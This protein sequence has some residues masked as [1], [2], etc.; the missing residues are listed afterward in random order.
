MM[1]DHSYSGDIVEWPLPERLIKALL[2]A[3]GLISE[4]KEQFVLSR[5]DDTEEAA[6]KRFE[7]FL[8]GAYAKT[9]FSGDRLMMDVIE[10]FAK[11]F[12]DL[13]T[14]NFVQQIVDLEGRINPLRERIPTSHASQIAIDW[15]VL[16]RLVVPWAGKNAAIV[17]Q[18]L[19]SIDEGMP[20]GHFW[21]LPQRHANGRV[22]S[23]LATFFAWWVD[24]CGMA[25]RSA[26]SELLREKL[27]AKYPEDDWNNLS[28]EIAKWV[29]RKP[30]LPSVEKIEKIAHVAMEVPFSDDV[31]QLQNEGPLQGRVC[32]C[33][34]FAVA[35][36]YDAHSLSLEIP[37]RVEQI[38]EILTSV[39]EDRS[40]NLEQ[41]TQ[42]KFV[43][44]MIRR[45]QKPT[46]AQIRVRLLLARTIQD[47]FSRISN[48]FGEEKAHAL[49]VIFRIAYN[50]TI[51]LRE[52]SDYQEVQKLRERFSE[53]FGR[54]FPI[55][56]DAPGSDEFL[57]LALSY[58]WRFPNS[59]END[60][61]PI[62]TEDPKELFK[63]VVR[64]NIH[65]MLNL[66]AEAM[67][68]E[69]KQLSDLSL[70]FDEPNDIA[71][72][73]KEAQKHL[74]SA[75]EIIEI[76]NEDDLITQWLRYI[77]SPHKQKSHS[78]LHGRVA[79]RIYDGIFPLDDDPIWS[80][81]FK[82]ALERAT[83]SEAGVI[84]E[85]AGLTLEGYY[86]TDIR[87]NKRLG[88][89]KRTEVCLARLKELVTQCG[90]W[91]HY[92]RMFREARFLV[93]TGDL[94]KALPL[95][96]T[97]L[98]KGASNIAPATSDILEDALTVASK[99][100]KF[101]TVLKHAQ[102]IDQRLLWY[103]ENFWGCPR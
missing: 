17:V 28:D 3:S 2:H 25:D 64:Q 99:C 88:D 18:S 43:G 11:A 68:L 54:H 22:T 29:S 12:A 92:A 42:E 21:F 81:R 53:Q 84:L 13:S 59:Y 27:E 95:Y 37:T 65:S 61:L 15:F 97:L 83:N 60:L 55:V 80:V 79:Q 76:V 38:E 58:I 100:R 87:R 82:E 73:M 86:L 41:A 71:D 98:T 56:F 46:I 24:L 69:P 10:G 101:K 34:E 32:R 44:F 23:P 74:R 9:P 45:W 47:L 90:P 5:T 85:S 102:A 6:A 91:F 50:L 4:V 77:Q 57:D 14:E 30:G 31:T 48:R 75:W 33:A 51:E 66:A 39:A 26:L 7:R 52:T 78:I 89:R 40:T 16:S 96:E 93:Q 35:R 49:S 36:G 8:N 1:R 94:T 63:Q 70:D 103:E 72:A 20:G 67:C 19:S 62:V